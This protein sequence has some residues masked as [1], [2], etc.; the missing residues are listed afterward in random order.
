[1]ARKVK[2]KK[3]YFFLFV[4]NVSGDFAKNFGGQ[5]RA[6]KN[7]LV[8]TSGT[9]FYVEFTIKSVFEHKK[10]LSYRNRNLILVQNKTYEEKCLPKNKTKK[11][12]SF[13]LNNLFIIVNCHHGDRG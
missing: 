2:V 6:V 10:D 4:E 12:F 13:K 1:M 3:C 9:R 5:P 7:L 11:K 8:R